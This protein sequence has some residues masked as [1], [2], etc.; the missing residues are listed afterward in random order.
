MLRTIRLR[1]ADRPDRDLAFEPADDETDPWALLRSRADGDGS[2]SL[3]DREAC[4]IEDVIDVVLVEP[5][6]VVG[7]TFARGLQ[8]EDA[9]TA[10]DENYDPP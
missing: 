4:S 7:T 2:I 9:A 10:L 8:D 5:E 6:P 3:G 1:F